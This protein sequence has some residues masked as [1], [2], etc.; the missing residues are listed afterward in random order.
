MT[1]TI[2]IHELRRRYKEIEE[3][4]TPFFL[5]PAYNLETFAKDMRVNRSYASRFINEEFGISFPVKMNE[6]RLDYLLR[7]R[8]NNPKVP[9]K[10]LLRASGFSSEITFRRAFKKKYDFL[11]RNFNTFDGKVLAPGL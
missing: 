3:R 9:W 6:M 7:L 1:G 11:P 4:E 10:T 8:R 2:T 5:D